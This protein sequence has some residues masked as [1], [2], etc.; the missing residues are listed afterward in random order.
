MKFGALPVTGK[1]TFAVSPAIR[2]IMTRLR[3][4]LSEAVCR[5]IKP[6][7]GSGAPGNAEITAAMFERAAHR[8]A[9]GR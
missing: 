7:R 1:Q 2:A 3:E 4:V 6:T 9:R 8:L 5:T